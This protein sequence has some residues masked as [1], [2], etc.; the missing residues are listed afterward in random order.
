MSES[1]LRWKGRLGRLKS[2]ALLI[3]LG[4]VV[5]LII[6]LINFSSALNS[7]TEQPAAVTV[8]QL[9]RGEVPKGRYVTVA[10]W[11]DYDVWY[12]ETEDSRTVASYY[13]LVDDDFLNLIV[14]KA[15]GSPSLLADFEP[16]VIT[17]MT[18]SMPSDLQELVRSDVAE[19]HEYGLEI[20]VNLYLAEGQKPMTKTTVLGL[21][22]AGAVLLLLAAIPLAM[23]GTVFGPAPVE[24]AAAPATGDSAAKASGVFRVLQSVD[25]LEVG[26][27]TRKFDN[28]VA[29]LVPLAGGR[30]LVYIH[31]ILT[32]RV[33]GVKAS[34]KESHWG[35]LIEQG[36]VISIEPGKLYAWKDRPAV[37]LRY[38]DAQGQEQELVVSFDHAAAQADFIKMLQ[39]L[40]FEVGA[41]MPQML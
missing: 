28:A 35:V 40:G 5:L 34:Q 6:G 13:V 16:V 19:I 27:K 22:I 7:D 32:T 38:H 29:N 30:L 23:P 9:T 17:G 15:A 10:G 26:H 4:G 3:G 20:N 25:P 14:V 33:Y 21:L 36:H 11:T 39:Q 12:T 41:G 31:H 1:A 2:V 8:G 18:R 24:A 37:G